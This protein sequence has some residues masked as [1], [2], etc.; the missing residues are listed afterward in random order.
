PD[1][2]TAA[3][4]LVNDSNPKV[5][6]QLACTLGEWNDPRAGAALGQLAVAHQADKFI[7][8]AVMSSALPHSL[9]LVD[10]VVAAGGP[11]LASLSEP[12]VNLSLATSQRD[13]LAR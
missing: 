7:T 1:V 8:A 4:K 12:L 5:L 6:L 2:I 10:A 13:S 11:A 3:V 9:A